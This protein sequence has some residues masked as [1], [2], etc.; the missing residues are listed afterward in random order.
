M[1]NN[2][3]NK[4]EEYYNLRSR[5]REKYNT[6]NIQ[7]LKESIESK[8]TVRYNHTIIKATSIDLSSYTIKFLFADPKDIEKAKTYVENC[9]IDELYNL[10]SINLPF[11]DSFVLADELRFII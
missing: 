1:K 4:F 10:F 5:L 11:V 3:N 6:E 9:I 8:V 7:R 2:N